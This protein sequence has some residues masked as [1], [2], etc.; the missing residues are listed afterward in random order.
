MWR[1]REACA[2]RW[3][4]VQWATPASNES[5]LSKCANRRRVRVRVSVHINVC[6]AV[7][8]QKKYVRTR[9]LPVAAPS[10][11]SPPPRPAFVRTTPRQC[12]THH[13]R[14]M[15]IFCTTAA[16]YAYPTEQIN[17]YL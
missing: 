14:F 7:L 15:L 16:H 4:A 8:S 17:P 12:R 6:G 10:R 9:P 3:E 5:A 2:W 1:A 11:M 13:T